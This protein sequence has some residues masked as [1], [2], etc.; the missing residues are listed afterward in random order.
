MRP[1]V[2][3]PFRENDSHLVA[4]SAFFLYAR[5]VPHQDHT[6]TFDRRLFLPERLSP[7]DDVC[8]LLPRFVS[9]A[10]RSAMRFCSA[11][12]LRATDRFT[13]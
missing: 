8:S 6:S 12:A 2:L 5:A 4:K 11:V 10:P 7:Q 1:P 3:L 13:D 9:F